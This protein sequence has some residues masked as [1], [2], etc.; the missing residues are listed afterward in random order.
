MVISGVDVARGGSHGTGKKESGKDR[1][2][3]S[4]QCG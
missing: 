3:E 4:R 1:N 2:K